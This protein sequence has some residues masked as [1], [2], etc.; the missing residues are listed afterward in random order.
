MTTTGSEPSLR[1]QLRQVTAA[2][3]ASQHR[4]VVLAAEFA[5]S[6]EWILDGSPTAAHWLAAVA[7]VED[8]T[9]REWIRIGKALRTLPV[10]A[11]A[12]EAGD[13]S[14]S[15]VRALT[16]LATPANEAELVEIARATPASGLGAA[17]A[18]WL[19]QNSDP[20]ELDAHQQ[21]RRSVKWRTEPDGMVTFTL[22]LRPLLAGTLIAVLTAIVMRSRPKATVG[23][24][25]ASAAEPHWPTMAQ[26]YADAVDTLLTN[27]P[28]TIVTEVILH[29]R[30]DGNTLD[31][32]TPV[33]D[34]VIEA[35][36]PTAFLRAMIHDA[37]RRPVNASTRRRHPTV[38][39]K[40]IVKER[41]RTCIDCGRHELLEYD[42]NPPYAQTQRT[43]TKELDLRCG[44]CHR[45]RHAND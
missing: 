22:R 35:I 8:C 42:H 12:F 3:A 26:Q 34:T 23:G 44:P 21:R 27:G 30:G 45:K 39:Q 6:P 9:A 13:I 19:N 25:H 38:R 18:A 1:T 7:D 40:R 11:A 41:D 20:A 31:D 43:H 4:L 14:Y 15:K 37:E 24:G 36:A 10:T 2:F 33:T 32:G 16:R 28:G 5:D 29:L 17:L